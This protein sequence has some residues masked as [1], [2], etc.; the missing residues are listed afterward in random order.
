L[1]AYADTPA[2]SAAAAAIARIF[3]MIL[4]PLRKNFASLAQ[5]ESEN[6]ARVTVFPL[7]VF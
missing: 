1:A 5:Q 2:V 4:P 3:F 7:P 6:L